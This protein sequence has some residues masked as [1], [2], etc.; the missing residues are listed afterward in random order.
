MESHGEPS[1]LHLLQQL[2][3]VIS[4]KGTLR[5]DRWHSFHGKPTL[6]PLLY[7]CEITT[8]QSIVE[9]Y[10]LIYA[11][12]AEGARALLQQ[13]VAADPLQ[14][15]FQQEVL[16]DLF[17]DLMTY[18]K[19]ICLTSRKTSV[20]VQILKQLL[21]MMYCESETL[22]GCGETTS[23]YECFQACKRMLVAHSHAAFATAKSSSQDGDPS[24]A[25]LGVFRSADVRLLTDAVMPVE[26]L[27][28][29]KGALFQQFLLY[30]KV[31]ICPEDSVTSYAEV[32][33]VQPLPP[34]D[35][36]KAVSKKKAEQARARNAKR[37]YAARSK[38]TTYTEVSP[39]EAE[40][41]SE[42]VSLDQTFSKF[43]KDLTIDE[44][45]EE[46]TKAAEA[47]AFACWH[48]FLDEKVEEAD[49][50]LLSA[51]TAAVAP[52]GAQTWR[53]A[54]ELQELLVL[55]HQKPGVSFV[56]SLCLGEASPAVAA[57]MPCWERLAAK[58]SSADSAASRPT[59]EY[60]E[61]LFDRCKG[62]AEF[63]DT[64]DGRFSVGRRS[65]RSS[66]EPLRPLRPLR[67]AG[68]AAR[69]AKGEPVSN[70]VQAPE[71]VEPVPKRKAFR[72]DLPTGQWK[73]PRRG[74]HLKVFKGMLPP[75]SLPD[76]A[77][78]RC[79]RPN[80]SPWKTAGLQQRP[81][82]QRPPPAGRP[83]CDPAATMTP[84][85][86]KAT[87]TAMRRAL[88]WQPW[89]ISKLKSRVPVESPE[90]ESEDE[91]PMEDL[92]S[93]RSLRRR[94]KSSE[95]MTLT[96]SLDSEFV[97]SFKANFDKVFSDLRPEKREG[98]RDALTSSANPICSDESHAIPLWQL[99]KLARDMNMS[100]EKVVEAKEIFD[101]HDEDQS[102]RL[103]FDE[104]MKV[105]ETLM[106][107]QVPD[108]MTVQHRIQTGQSKQLLNQW[109]KYVPQNSLDLGFEDFLLWYSCTGFMTDLL[110][111]E[112]EKRIRTLAK[113]NGLDAMCMDRVRKSFTSFD[114]DRSG[115]VDEE[116]FENVLR[117]VMNIP[118]HL[119]IPPSRIRFFWK[120]IDEDDS[121]K[122]SF[123]E[124]LNFWLCRFG[125][126]AGQKGQLLSIEDYYRSTRRMGAEYLDPPPE[127]DEITEAVQNF[128]ANLST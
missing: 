110:V 17:E 121:G 122:A 74:C 128:I 4:V 67:P 119:Q 61:D 81:W 70:W 88:A 48:R 84:L 19:T 15:E 57:R 12:D 56:N 64:S 127:L 13:T 65:S 31:L 6:E 126:S 69:P 90:S 25:T 60:V 77:R 120:E 24:M 5:E 89:L 102:G 109:L 33:L 75:P 66:Q 45:H 93:S 2:A 26:S 111:D 118:P 114:L 101:A 53:E 112:K 20:F 96:T 44:H 39:E 97:R 63:F 50:S 40:A 18:A 117:E 72:G 14:R 51:I 29:L 47:S 38:E 92:T 59:R 82:N 115:E 21:D 34:Q 86:A 99:H 80:P 78:S 11:E 116:E 95:T 113:V 9:R 16:L 35:L 108:N 125:K 107:R 79:C 1:L 73:R 55:M 71:A 42:G 43:P 103:S 104:I 36:K 68:P 30:Q 7:K 23:I 91:V 100:L 54:V 83:I 49:F 3:S 32:E 22:R 28:F 52:M 76:A 98:K 94:P 27:Q 8:F 46:S 10:F 123:H 85:V 106:D 62:I 87:E 58:H 41:Q 124:F 105:I 37:A